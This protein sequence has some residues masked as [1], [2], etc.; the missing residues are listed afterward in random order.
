[1]CGCNSIAFENTN[2]KRPADTPKTE[3]KETAKCTYTNKREYADTI[4]PLP[5]D[6]KGTHGTTIK[7]NN[8]ILRDVLINRAI[9]SST[10]S[11]KMRKEIEEQKG[12]SKKKTKFD[13]KEEK[14]NSK[15]RKK[16]KNLAFTRLS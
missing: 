10:P 9:K 13:G 7:R 11:S 12:K 15:L 2:Y 3:H 8:N 5:I 14:N 6:K 4:L 1:M 16:R